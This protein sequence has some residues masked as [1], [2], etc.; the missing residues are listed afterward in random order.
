[1]VEDTVSAHRLVEAHR[2]L[3]G[4]MCAIE[5]LAYH[6]RGHPGTAALSALDDAIVRLRSRLAEHMTTE[7]R[8]I[9][10]TLTTDLGTE[11]VRA[12]IEDHQ[13]IRS[14]IE[15]LVRVRARL[16][17][18]EV[19]FDNVRWVLYVIAGLVNLH[20]RKEEIAYVRLLEQHVAPTH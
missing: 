19:D 16:S 17:P 20:L 14:W 6:L 13:E 8:T 10:P 11:G 3:V 2:N 18:P 15:E 1:M 9:Y 4:D 5:N 12:M 7:E